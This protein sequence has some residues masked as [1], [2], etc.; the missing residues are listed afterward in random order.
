MA[1]TC[2]CADRDC[3]IVQAGLSPLVLDHVFTT[4]TDGKTA[5]AN[6]HAFDH[7]ELLTGQ[8]RLVHKAPYVPPPPPEKHVDLDGV[9]HGVVDE[10][11]ASAFAKV[12]SEPP[13]PPPPL[14]DDADKQIQ[15]TEGPKSPSSGRS[16]FTRA[17]LL[18]LTQG[19]HAHA[20]T[21]CKHSDPACIPKGR[22]ILLSR[23]MA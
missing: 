9:L 10:A 19:T 1:R 12:L 3:R 4:D 14:N 15:G 6:V 8:M 2:T 22:R 5:W 23:K 17:L 16:C 20:H 11:I 21:Q 7:G 13:P 18:E